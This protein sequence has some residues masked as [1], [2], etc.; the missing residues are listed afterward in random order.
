MNK[1]LQFTFAFVLV[2]VLVLHAGYS[3]AADADSESLKATLITK[4]ALDTK[5]PP[6]SAITSHSKMNVC[7]LGD[8]E[9]AKLSK[10]FGGALQELGREYALIKNV[11]S[12]AIPASC[13]I[14][15]IRDSEEPKLS[16]ILQG[17]AG[18]TVLTVG[19]ID[20]FATKG[21]MIELA[22]VNKKVKV[23]INNKAAKNAKIVIGA[24]LLGIARNVIE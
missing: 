14:V 2:A 3:Y 4:F 23:A 24:D 8:S 7:V 10:V 9:L 13:N 6:E 12:A 11:N 18:K 20:D 16:Q 22:Y 5:W 21:G 19:D 15:F 17:L 1:F